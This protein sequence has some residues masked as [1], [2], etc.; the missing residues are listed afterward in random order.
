MLFPELC[1]G[2]GACSYLC[3]GGALV[4]TGCIRQLCQRSGVPVIS[5]IAYDENAST[6]IQC[7]QPL[8]VLNAPGIGS[9]V[10]DLY[11]KTMAMLT[12]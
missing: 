1:H 2:C 3:P 12:N 8:V 4:K 7:G 9:Q 11:Q 6:A 10:K 5:E